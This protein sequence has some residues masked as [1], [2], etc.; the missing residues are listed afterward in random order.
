MLL[1]EFPLRAR[2]LAALNLSDAVAGIQEYFGELLYSFCPEVVYVH[3]ENGDIRILIEQCLSPASKGKVWVCIRT[4]ERDSGD[5][6]S[7]GTSEFFGIYDFSAS[8][9]GGSV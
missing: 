4:G 3:V 6:E 7:G 2:V 5:A 8:V 9:H 1:P